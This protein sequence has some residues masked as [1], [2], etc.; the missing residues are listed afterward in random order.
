M[1]EK[2]E[3]IGILGLGFLGGRILGKLA[4]LSHSLMPPGAVSFRLGGSFKLVRDSR[5][6]CG[7]DSDHSSAEGGA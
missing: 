1:N 3:L 4:F 7:D 2:T 5:K 6:I